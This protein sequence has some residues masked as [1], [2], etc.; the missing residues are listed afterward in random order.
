[1]SIAQ[2]LKD[3]PFFS[4]LSGQELEQVAEHGQ[5]ETHQPG[6]IVVREGSAATSMYVILN[7]R[8]RIYKSDEDGTQIDI[9]MLESGNFFGELALLD[10]GSR[11][12]TVACLT[13]CQ[14]FILDQPSFLNLLALSNSSMIH[15][16]FAI[17]AQRVRDTSERVFREEHAHQM[18]AANM[19][20]ERLRSLSQMVAG[21]A[22]EI[23]TPLGTINAAAGMIATRLNNQTVANL[24]AADQKANRLWGEIME[25]SQLIQSSIARAHRLVQDFKK[26]SVQQLTDVRERTDLPEL[27]RSIVDLFKITA[28]KAR[29]E[30]TL[31]N[32]LAPDR[33]IWDGYPGYLTQVLLNLLANVERYA[34]SDDKGG[35]I[36]IT[37]KERTNGKSPGF[38][39]TVRDQG[40]GIPAENLPRVFDPFFTTGRAKGGSGLG[41]AI[42]YNIITSALHGEISIDS[43][44]GTGTTVTLDLPQRVPDASASD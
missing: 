37:L 30:I 16:M 19:E 39:V 8:V 23:N 22:H 2:I 31:H 21:V 34:Y 44:V 35:P 12:A 18:M 27:V 42:V 14:F 6:E 3:I 36:D 1:M 32:A 10:Q 33:G 38:V 25:A 40:Q 4:H 29:L 20:L 26:I 15:R 28:K 7:G 24:L 11:S 17:L 5:V 9:A 13:P 41:L 43:E